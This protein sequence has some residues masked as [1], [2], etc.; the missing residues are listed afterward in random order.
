LNAETDLLQRARSGDPA[1]GEQLY[2]QYLKNSKS[3]Q[4]LLRHAL[5]N[6]EDRDEILHEIYL[7]LMSG[8][9]LFRG[10]SRL[11][12]YIYQ[13]ARITVFQKFRKEN[14]LKRGKVYRRIAEPFD[15]ASGQES[16]PEYFY[17]VRQARELLAEMIG[18]LPDAYKEVLRLRVLEDLSYEEIAKTLKIPLNT[19]ST[20]IHKGKKLLALIFKERGLTE[21]FEL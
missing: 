7:Q 17:Q 5:S 16:S 14:T 2:E 15:L 6:P 8:R 13:V 19:V 21:V 10:D 9:N 1:A 11:S 3:I 4:G 18:R 20:K 12:T